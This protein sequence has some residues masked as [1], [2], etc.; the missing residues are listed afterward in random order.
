MSVHCAFLY[1]C[2]EFKLIFMSTI[3]YISDNVFY[4][5]NFQTNQTEIHQNP[6]GRSY[7]AFTSNHKRGLTVL[8]DYGKNPVISFNYMYQSENSFDLQDICKL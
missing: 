8:A 7:Q 4:R 2:N 6:R 3:G 5:H 1:P